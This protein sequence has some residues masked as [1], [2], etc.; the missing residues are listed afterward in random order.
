MSDNIIDVRAIIGQPFALRRYVLPKDH[1]LC[2]PE[3]P[4]KGIPKETYEKYQHTADPVLRE[5][6]QQIIASGILFN[7]GEKMLNRDNRVDEF[8][9]LCKASTTDL[10]SV[11][12][13]GD[14]TMLVMSNKCGPKNVAD[15]Q[16]YYQPH[17]YD[18]NVGGNTLRSLG[19]DVETVFKALKTNL[20]NHSTLYLSELRR[21]VGRHAPNFGRIAVFNP[22]FTKAI[23]EHLRITTLVDPC[24]GWGGRML[25]AMA[26]GCAYTGIDPFDKTCQGLRAM[27]QELGGHPTPQVEIIEGCAEDELP[28]MPSKSIQASLTSPPFFDKE[29]YCTSPTQSVERYPSRSEWER[30]FLE[31]VITETLRVVRDYAMW[32]V[33]ADMENLVTDVH[34]RHSWQLLCVF[35]RRGNQGSKDKY[36]RVMCFVPRAFL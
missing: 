28:H 32:N 13:N 29:R 24:A 4:K 34:A 25:G 22:F 26:A 12:K 11:P 17:F 20:T 21:N 6:A 33:P 14:Q 1:E 35:C 7:P 3:V 5:C 2:Q 15:L 16:L 23:L 31:P 18:V 30:G 10:L 27:H 8:T 9:K 19:N 36:E